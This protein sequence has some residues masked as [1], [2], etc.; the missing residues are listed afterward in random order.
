MNHTIWAQIE[1]TDG[2]YWISIDGDVYSLARKGSRGEKGGGKILL[3][4][5]DIKGYLRFKL[6]C[7]KDNHINAKSHRLVA[8]RYMPNP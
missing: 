8:I 7:G 3:P 1:G 2:K 6:F 5:P 4:A